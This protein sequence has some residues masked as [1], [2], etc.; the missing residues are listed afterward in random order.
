MSSQESNI[1]SINDIFD[2]LFEPDP[3]TG[4]DPISAAKVAASQ[5]GISSYYD[6]GSC[7]TAFEFIIALLAM[8]QVTNEREDIC[9]EHFRKKAFTKCKLTRGAGQWK[10]VEQ[11]LYLSQR[12]PARMWYVILENFS[13]QDI[14]GNIIPAVKRLLS[15]PRIQ[16]RNQYVASKAP[17]KR[18]VRK[19]GYDDKGHLPDRTRGYTRMVKDSPE[20]VSILT[21]EYDLEFQEPNKSY[22]LFDPRKVVDLDKA[23]LVL[24][25]DLFKVKEE[26][27][28]VRKQE[29]L[30]RGE[31]KKIKR[32]IRKRTK[33]ERKSRATGEK[34]GNKDS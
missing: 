1:I 16:W 23:V 19:R 4:I 24:E 8:V 17:V 32:S 10:I 13:P 21:E 2:V 18:L 31:I 11:M 34:L 5:S 15:S 12:V 33:K 14:F 7:E 29:D 28:N 20:L 3:K 22:Y 26:L 30:L 6:V 9:R 25:T 27:S